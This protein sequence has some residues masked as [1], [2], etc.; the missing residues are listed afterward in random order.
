MSLTVNPQGFYCIENNFKRLREE[1]R[2][3]S[4]E[5]SNYKRFKYGKGFNRLPPEILSLIAES[6]GVRDLFN[7]QLINM[8]CYNATE[9]S[10][11]SRSEPN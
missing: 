5:P 11:K 10:F 4:P 9:D 1:D 8:D 7:F 3:P 6:L 2:E